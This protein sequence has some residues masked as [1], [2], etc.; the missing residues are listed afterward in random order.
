MSAV[1]QLT[2]EGPAMRTTKTAIIFLSSMQ[3]HTSTIGCVAGCR[4]RDQ[5]Q[6]RPLRLAI[7]HLPAANTALCGHRSSCL[8]RHS[9]RVH[10]QLAYTLLQLI[11]NLNSHAGEQS[12]H[13]R[14]RTSGTIIS[15]AGVTQNYARH[16]VT[17]GM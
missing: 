11:V 9:H 17:S 7:L 12:A 10:I 15:N 8:G 13:T 14:G 16:V 6:Q 4:C 2:A 3:T 5:G 1:I